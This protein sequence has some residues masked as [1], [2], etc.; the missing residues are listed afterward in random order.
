MA[1]GNAQMMSSGVITRRQCTDTTENNASALSEPL[2]PLVSWKLP[3][4]QGWLVV[5]QL[6]P[7]PKPESALLV[8]MFDIGT[9]HTEDVIDTGYREELDD[10]VDHPAPPSHLIT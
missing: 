4:R 9:V 8:E 3:V 10:V 2:W 5:V 6:A 1:S 7:A